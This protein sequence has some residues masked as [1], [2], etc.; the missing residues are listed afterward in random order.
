MQ[1][2]LRCFYPH[3]QF[4]YYFNFCTVGSFT[5]FTNFHI[6]NK[7]VYS[8]NTTVIELGKKM[9]KFPLTDFRHLVCRHNTF[10]FDLKVNLHTGDQLIWPQQ[11]LPISSFRT[12]WWRQKLANFCLP[13]K[14][15]FAF[16]SRS[17]RDN[18]VSKHKLFTRH[19]QIWRRLYYWPLC[20]E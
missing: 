16:F 8:E 3:N 15:I 19:N 1:T 6:F 20:N 10:V 7:E 5:P 12:Y 11:D 4:M 13:G 2:L 17:F 9:L 18:H 14:L